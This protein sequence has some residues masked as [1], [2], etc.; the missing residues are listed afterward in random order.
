MAS[1]RL[2]IWGPL[3][4]LYGAFWLWY[5]PLSSPF[6]RAEVD[7]II[8]EAEANGADPLMISRLQDFLGGDDGGSFV[9]VN[10]LDFADE[11]AVLPATG[12]DATAQDLLGHYMEYMYAGLLR[13]ACHPVFVGPV[14]SDSLDLVG[15]EGA[16]TWDTAALMRY[17]SRRDLWEVISNPIFAD[18]HE[19]KMAALEKTIAFPVVPQLFLS[20]LRLILGL[21]LG[22]L[23]GLLDMLLVRRG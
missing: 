2:W 11:P 19:Y 5:T 21:A 7:A 9:M 4:V 3:L 15:I 20:D 13:R 8:T 23:A 6:T 12:P 14:V 18:R 17:R 10:L 22:A 16:E 1:T